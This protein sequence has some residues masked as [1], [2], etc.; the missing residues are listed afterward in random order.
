MTILFVDGF[1]AYSAATEFTRKWTS[2]TSG[3]LSATAGR[4]GGRC[5]QFPSNG[6]GNIQKTLSAAKTTVVTGFAVQWPG[7]MTTFGPCA[8][9][10]LRNSTTTIMTL[11]Y[12]YTSQSYKVYRGT[13]GGTLLQTVHAPHHAVYNHIIWK[14]LRNASTGTIDL[15]INGTSVLAVTNQNTGASDIDNVRY[16]F[17]SGTSGVTG[18]MSLDDVFITDSESLGDRRVYT[19]V[20]G[21]DD[22]VQFTPSSGTNNSALVDELPTNN[23]TD[24]VE[25][26]TVGNKD[27]YNLTNLGI[28]PLTVDCVAVNAINRKDDAGTKTVRAHIFSNATNSDGATTSPSTSYTNT[29]DIFA[30]NPDGS[31]AWTGTSVDALKAGFEIVS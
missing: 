4:F 18:T 19:I 5:A 2:N 16:G 8:I 24:Y 25:S 10:E 14:V 27:R 7:T 17:I 3:T 28:T 26:S 1:D 20:P 15:L 29:Q 11:A 30:L 31:V 13:T 12:D 6:G 22:S 9:V 21:S 23:D